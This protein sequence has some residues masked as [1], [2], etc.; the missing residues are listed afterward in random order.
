MAVYVDD[1]VMTGSV[2]SGI[3][4]V[5]QDLNKE[6]QTMDLGL[7]KYFFRIETL[8]SRHGIILAQRKYILDLLK[9]NG[10]LGCKPIETL[11]ERNVKLCAG[12]S[13]DI[14]VGQFQQLVGN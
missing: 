2:L 10:K 13:S 4:L 11:M 7:R 14:D 3:Q 6:F 5:K 12:I 1:I 9:E 8:Q